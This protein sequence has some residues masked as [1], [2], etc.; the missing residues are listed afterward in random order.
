MIEE[1]EQANRER[2]GMRGGKQRD[3]GDVD[4]DEYELMQRQ[5]IITMKEEID[6][7]NVTKQIEKLITELGGKEKLKIEDVTTNSDPANLGL[8]TFKSIGTKNGFFKKF[9]GEK[10]KGK[11][12]KWEGGD[13]I[14][15]N[16]NKTIWERSID[17]TLRRVKYC[18]VEDEGLRRVDTKIKWGKRTAEAV[19]CQGKT[20][21]WIQDDGTLMTKEEGD[22]IKGKVEKFMKEW[23]ENMRN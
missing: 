22:K 20:I 5:A 12:F 14:W 23:K 2:T 4:E 19:K 7:D 17:T 10:R 8:I 6:S 16:S 1:L 9:Y 15:V 11:E 3:E 21:A 13:D 18:L